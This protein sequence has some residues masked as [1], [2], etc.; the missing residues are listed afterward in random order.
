MAR[1]RIINH[2]AITILKATAACG[3]R[4]DRAEAVRSL[5]D[6][7][8]AVTEPFALSLIDDIHALSLCQA[9]GATAA[10][11][12]IVDGSTCTE[13][14]EI[15]QTAELGGFGAT[16][17]LSTTCAGIAQPPRTIDAVSGIGPS[18]AAVRLVRDHAL[19]LVRAAGS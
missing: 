18:E 12:R 5:A 15:V 14:L 17:I 11:T 2:N 1:F 3:D 4:A 9:A 6:K 19:T 13:P 7:R 16:A 10:G 8:T